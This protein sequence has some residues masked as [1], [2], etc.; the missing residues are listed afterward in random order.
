MQAAIEGM[1][2]MTEN[3]APRHADTLVHKTPSCILPR[4]G[5]PSQLA[6]HDLRWLVDALCCVCAADGRISRGEFTTVLGALKAAGVNRSDHEL[7]TLVEDRCREVHKAGI[8]HSAEAIIAAVRASGNQPLG[9]LIC[10]LQAG[11]PTSDGRPTER[12]SAVA[13]LFQDA[14]QAATLYHDTTTPDGQSTAAGTCRACKY[15][16]T[17]S[18][19][20]CP[21]CGQ[22]VAAKPAGRT[23]PMCRKP[24]T[25]GSFCSHCGVRA[26]PAGTVS[27]SGFSWKWAVLSVPI[28]MGT[29]F[30]C[31]VP[32]TACGFTADDFQN[33]PA[34]AI[35]VIGFGLFMGGLLAG[36]LSPARTVL[37]PGVGII[38]MLVVIGLLAGESPNLIGSGVLFGLGSLGAALGEYL[39]QQKTR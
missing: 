11:V 4:M 15:P 1:K 21:G 24:V 22:T 8:R 31:C 36:F 13:R 23:C 7:R 19:R 6:D 33:N 32:V 38:F 3:P 30:A 9:A 10:R 2:A 5:E 35:V 25:E 12:E 34:L 18:D 28:V 29:V 14:F 37:E 16:L 26:E 20:F 39:Q 17:A 27:A